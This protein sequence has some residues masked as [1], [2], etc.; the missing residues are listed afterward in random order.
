MQQLETIIQVILFSFLALQVGYIVFFSVAAKL[1]KRKKFPE[2]KTLRTIRVFIPGY[3][4]DSVIVET[5]RAALAHIYAGKFEV[6]VI[7]DSFSPVTMQALKRL[8]VKVI[9]VCFTKSTKGKALQKAMELT[10]HDPMDIIIVLDADNQMAPGFLYAVNNAFAAGHTAVQGHRT[11]KNLNTSFAFLDACTEEINNNIFRRGHTAA[12]LPSA[13][14]GSGMA[15]S[16]PLFES[17]MT[18]IGDTAGEDKEF[19]FRIIRQNFDIAFLD[20]AFVYDE[21]VSKKEVFSKQRSRWLAMQFEYFQKYFAEGFGLLLKG[22]I[23]FFNKSFQTFLIPSV[24]LVATVGLWWT[25]TAIFSQ[26]WLIHSSSLLFALAI[27][28]FSGIP[29]KWYNKQLLSAILNIPAALIG[30]VKALL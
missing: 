26:S 22:N 28:L 29:A 19:E 8:P 14:I 30:M 5:A 25:Y 10:S 23:A 4:E 24:M 13:L 11:A 18:G 16:Y 2:A 9:E 12:G 27:S 21:K 6:I 15:F 3:K 1:A 17:L 7:A 20:G